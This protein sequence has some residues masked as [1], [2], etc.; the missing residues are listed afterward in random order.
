MSLSNTEIAFGDLETELEITRK[1]LARLPEESF[2]WAPHEKSMTLG[3]LASHVTDLPG[4]L[5]AVLTADGF[6]MA[7]PRPPSVAA[8]TVDGV[9]EAWDANVAGLQS[10][11]G[12][13]DEAGLDS[14]WALTMGEEVIFSGHRAGVF[15]RLGTSHLVH[16]RAQ[17]GVYLRLLGVPVPAMFGPSADEQS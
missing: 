17:L 2:D 6:D 9:L 11:L 1:T 3:A 7:A 14:P 16:H 15:R 13:F 8:T 5:V 10:A 12:E 4:L